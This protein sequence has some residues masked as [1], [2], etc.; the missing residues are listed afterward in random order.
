[1]LVGT[2][3]ALIFASRLLSPS[4]G[5]PGE[6]RGG[7]RFSNLKSEISF[8]DDRRFNPHHLERCEALIALIPWSILAVHSVLWWKGKMGSSGD[9]RYLL[10]VGPFFALLGARGWEWTWQRFHW[11]IP[12]LVAGIVALIPLSANFMHGQRVVP[13]PLYAD[14][15]IARKA[16]EWYRSDAKIRK[17]FPKIMPTLPGVPYSMDISNND[18]A[19]FV[20]VCKA[21]VSDPPPGAVMI[22]DPVFGSANSNA[23]MCVDQQLIHASG[24]LHYKHFQ[25]YDTY[26]EVYL[27]P[28]TT[29]G[30][31]TRAQYKGDWE[32]HDFSFP[33]FQLDQE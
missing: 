10:I 19:R 11:R 28:K 7:G 6:G 21:Y 27:S 32:S 3:I 12:H 31:D 22:W 9:L 23:D 25:L 8:S 4:P 15:Y 1:M 16:A 20:P 18:K 2:G 29:T 30:E 33:Q 14:G 17:D 26:C 5:T 13:F 24:W